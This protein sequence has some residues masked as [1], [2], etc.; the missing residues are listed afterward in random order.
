MPLKPFA[1]MAALGALAF[2]GAA[3]AADFPVQARTEA[4]EVRGA[5][6]DGVL[7]FKGLPFAAPPVGPL[8]WRPPQPAAPWS[9]VRPALAYGH[10]CMQKPFPSDAAPLG[11]EPA[12]DCLVL[13]IWRPAEAR[14]GKLPVMVWIYGG[15]FV[16]GGSSPAVYDGSQFARRG[17]VLVSFNYRLGRFGFFAHPAL[18]AESRDGLLGNYGYMD[19]IA[20][21]QWVKRNIAAFG[22]DPDNV[23]VF[24]ESAGGG[25][26]HMLM[27]SPMARGLFAKAIVESGGGLGGFSQIR[28]LHGDVPGG[29]VSAESIGVA[30]AEANGIEGSGPKALAALRALPAEKVVGGLNMA[31]M[32]SAA[33]TYAGPMLDGRVVTESTGQT[34]LADRQAKVPLLIGANSMDIGFSN[35]KSMDELLAPYGANRDRARAA[36]DPQNTGDLKTVGYAMAM[37]RFMVG[38]AREIAAGLAKRGQRTYE[39]RFSYVATSMRSQWPGA[40]HAT[41][42]PFVFD[43]VAAKYGKDLTADD[44]ATAQAANAYWVNFARTGN[45]DGPGLPHWPAY[46]PR[47]DE[48]MD[49]TPTGPKGGPD[50]WKA[51]LDVTNAAA[52]GK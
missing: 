9:G 37:D 24:G 6:Q 39:F 17:V 5:V 30:F 7:A 4:G 40:P 16:N 1:L 42:I 33:T 8:R 28:R 50:P 47:K 44:E 35:A 46:D 25:S 3:A 45:P 38:P 48:I 26:V 32:G 23:T 43:T 10:D 18:T 31:S 27:T 34:Y 20:A 12:E 29:P 52:S 22:G 49:F 51:R 21:L 41:E 14:P 11:T 15:G 19:Q 36:Y 13:N 2:G